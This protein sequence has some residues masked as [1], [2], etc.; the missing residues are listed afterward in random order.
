[1]HQGRRT[2]RLPI[3]GILVLIF[4]QGC[5]GL[6]D[7]C[8]MNLC[9]P[10]DTGTSGSGPAGGGGASGSDAG[11][12]GT[13]GQTTGGGGAG[14][15]GGAGGT[16]GGQGGTGGGAPSC[17]PSESGSPVAD[18]CGI[19]VSPAG[20]DEGDGTK[21]S[22]WK[23]LGKAVEAAAIGS[24]RVYACTG[25]FEGAV[26]LPSGMS[27]FGGLAC[28][29][30]WTHDGLQKTEITAAAGEIPL[31]IAPGALP[32]RV[33]DVA[34]TA[35]DA[36]EPGGSSIA[37]LAELVTVSF[38]RCS[39]T[40][41]DAMDG[42]SGEPGGPAMPQAMSGAAGV[43]ACGNLPPK[44]LAPK[45]GAGAENDCQGMSLLAG[46]G[47]TGGKWSSGLGS[48]GEAGE[49]GLGG[50]AGNGDKGGAMLCTG[51]GAGTAGEDGAPGTGADGA[52]WIDN[53]GYHGLAGGDGLAGTLGASGG[54]GGGGRAG[55]TCNGG[56]GGGGGAG[57]CRGAGGR[58]GGAGGSSMAFVSLNAQVTFS[59]V[60]LAAGNAGNGGKGGDGQPGQ[61]GGAGGPGGPQGMADTTGG[62]QGGPGGNGGNGGHGGGG[63]GGH[64]IGVAYVGTVP[65]SEALTEILGMPGSGGPGG[66][67]GAAAGS[68]GQAASTMAF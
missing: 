17:D 48:S 32:A 5:Y 7:D 13:G 44:S 29:D 62:C 64:A 34:V 12:T 67:D 10:S 1:M 49:L 52:G 61:L 56:G 60:T 59:G 11:G 47:G 40:A 39:F 28:E 21:A 23:T 38:V 30:G 19:F 46:N 24:G 58:G 4:A 15:A 20:S 37:A 25:T 31:R 16:G 8:E 50:P 22:P 55:A 35:K 2:H 36:V 41:G 57:G 42:L 33:E 9:A 45:G 18:D 66:G 51:G 68:D 26:L 6:A 14:G 43:E 54:G 65:R 27:L 63:A 3:A 53:A